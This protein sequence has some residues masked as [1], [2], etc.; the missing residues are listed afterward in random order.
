MNRA[1]VCALKSLHTIDR[2][3]A[4]KR[5]LKIPTRLFGPK[6]RINHRR[7][8]INITFDCNL[9]CLNCNRSCSQA[10]AK[11]H[12]TLEQ[13]EKF[14]KESQEKA[15]KWEQIVLMGGEPTVHPAI[16]EIVDMFFS[17]KRESNHDVK[18]IL[19]TNGFGPEVK[20]ILRQLPSDMRVRNTNKKSRR[21]KEF[22][23]FNVAPIDLRAYKNA[24]YSN[25]CDVVWS[26]GTGLSKYGYYLCSNASGIDR[27]FGMDIGRRELPST[28]DEMTD[29]A[30][31]LCPFCGRFRVYRG[32]A[33]GKPISPAWETAYEK[34]RRQRPVLTEY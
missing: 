24:D 14:I 10:P 19:A 22:Y 3:L 18:L 29:Q 30:E 27:V 5:L 25:K 13:I 26:C 12:M 32:I 33:H 6:N 1:R 7:I 31:M 8:E 15:R 2:F 23:A 34:Y 20:D 11:D 9:K 17:Y 16:L 28:D 4:P 21:Q